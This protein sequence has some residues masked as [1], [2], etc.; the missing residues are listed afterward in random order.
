MSESAKATQGN[1]TVPPTDP[2]TGQQD[3]GLDP[4]HRGDFAEGES[5]THVVPGTL[6]GD[7]A[8]GQEATPRTGTIQPKGDFA[9]GEEHEPVDP[10]ALRGNFARGQEKT[11]RK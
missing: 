2:S 8:A 9:S 5:K 6:M 11:P 4:A 7:F 3:G 10:A 1:G